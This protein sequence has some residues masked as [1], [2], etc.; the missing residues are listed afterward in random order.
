M[1]APVAAYVAVMALAPGERL[2]PL[3]MNVAVPA[4]PKATT[5]DEP[6][7][8]VPAAKVTLPV[9]AALPVTGAMVAVRVVLAVDAMLAA[10]AVSVMFVPTPGVK[11]LHFVAR[12]QAST[13]PSPV[14]WSYPAPAV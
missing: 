3:T 5:T 7:G 1:K 14:A 11:L 6:S 12:F 10:V 2:L 4:V 9:G 8:A 13:E